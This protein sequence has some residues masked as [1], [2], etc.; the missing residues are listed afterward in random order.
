MSF[1]VSGCWLTFDQE[2]GSIV[3]AQNLGRSLLAVAGVDQQG[4]NEAHRS[5]LGQPHDVIAVHTIKR[6]HNFLIHTAALPH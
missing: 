2:V 6:N 1:I 3:V 5:W 4:Q